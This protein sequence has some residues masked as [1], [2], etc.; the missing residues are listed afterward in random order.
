MLGQSIYKLLLS[1]KNLPLIRFPAMTGWGRSALLRSWESRVKKSTAHYS[2]ILYST[3]CS[4]EPVTGSDERR[5]SLA[6]SVTNRDLDSFE[7][8]VAWAPA[9]DPKGRFSL[10][11]RKL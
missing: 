4:G 5:L 7:R 10:E 11:G 2:E 6:A 1:H 9:A 8:A 3:R